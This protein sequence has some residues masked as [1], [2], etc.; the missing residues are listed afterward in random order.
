MSDDPR[1]IKP[2][3]EKTVKQRVKNLLIKYE[4]YYFMPVQT[5]YGS[6]TLDFLGSHKGRFFAVETKAPGKVPT[7]RQEL[8]MALINASGGAV[9]VIG[10]EY[11][12]TTKTFS[13]INELESWLLLGR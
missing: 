4:C 12:A 13:G 5:G 7:P 3:R 2:I 11:F 6:P 1:P 9:F 8:T 10:E